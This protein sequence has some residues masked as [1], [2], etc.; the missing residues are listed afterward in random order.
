MAGLLPDFENKK[1]CDDSWQRVIQNETSLLKQGSEIESDCAYNKKR[2]SFTGGA[3][4]VRHP[5]A[6]KEEVTRNV[7]EFTGQLLRTVGLDT[8]LLLMQPCTRG[9]IFLCT[10]N[11]WCSSILYTHAR[12]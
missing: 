1:H 9:H 7:R 12:H 6:S 5:Y 8:V 10:C 3:M 4:S 11:Y 2:C